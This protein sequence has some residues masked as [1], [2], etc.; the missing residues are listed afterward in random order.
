MGQFIL[1]AI[2]SVALGIAFGIFSSLL[3]KYFRFLT[4]SSVTE[5]LLIFIIALMTYYL[6]EAL[7]LSGMI[8]LLTSGIAMAHYT[9]YN[10]SP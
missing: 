1:L 6:S 3:F 2:Y 9:W 4:H 10:L 8:S 5:T 7:E